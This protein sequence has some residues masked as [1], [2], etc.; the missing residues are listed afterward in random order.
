MHHA[1]RRPRCGRAPAAAG[2]RALRATGGRRRRGSRHQPRTLPRSDMAAATRASVLRPTRSAGEDP[3]SAPAFRSVRSSVASLLVASYLLQSPHDSDSRRPMTRAWVEIDLG[4]LCRNGA[5]LA[6]RAGVP[7]LPMVKADGYGV[8]GLRAALALDALEPWGFGVSTVTEGRRAASRR[9][10]AAHRRL[11]AD[12]PH[13][14]RRAA[15]RRPHAGARRSSGD[16]VVGAHRTSLAPADRH[17]NVARG[18]ALGA[19]W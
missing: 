4:A 17:R 11:H 19:R 5:A 1:P 10:H 12:S 6:A 2:R 16:R 8:G 13:R 14:D 18:N 9:H 3:S 15:P 7:L